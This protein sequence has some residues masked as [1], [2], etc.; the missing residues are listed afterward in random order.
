[1]AWIT[2]GKTEYKYVTEVRHQGRK[3]FISSGVL[4]RR[5]TFK[6][7]RECAIYVDK[8]LIK[9]GKKPVNILKPKK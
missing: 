3:C 6:T 9:K 2:I 4:G 8:L 1:M 7:D 5:V